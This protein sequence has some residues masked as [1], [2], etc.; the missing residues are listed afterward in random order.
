MLSPASQDRDART[1]TLRRRLWAL[2]GER[3]AALAAGL[4]ANALYMSHLDRDIAD[5]REAFVGHAVTDIAVLR[6]ALSGR[7]QG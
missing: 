1:A 4:G 6:A 2:E 5:T 7:L 3:H